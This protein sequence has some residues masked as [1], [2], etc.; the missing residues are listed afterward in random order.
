MNDD[1]N[2]LE[3]LLRQFQPAE[4]S[5]E[6]RQRVARDLADLSDERV[7]P[8]V[9]DQSVRSLSPAWL[10]VA[11]AAT[12]LF[13][14][15][16]ISGLRLLDRRGGPIAK[17]GDQRPETRVDNLPG[18]PNAA[19]DRAEVSPPPTMLAYRLASADSVDRLD[20]LLDRHARVLLPPS[21]NGDLAGIGLP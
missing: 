2:K 6:F 13:V 21:A 17:Q 1:L 3:D 15:A 14:I 16:L 5:D 9:D 12:V 11:T 10:I 8:F 18:Q 4:V 19:S 7:A 20:T